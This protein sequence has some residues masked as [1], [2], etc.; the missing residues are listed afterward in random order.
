MREVGGIEEATA[1]LRDLAAKA[2]ES[3]GADSRHVLVARHQLALCAADRGDPV[4]AERELRA[5]LEATSGALGSD[6]T[7]VASVH[8]SLARLLGKHGQR[9]EAAQ[10][11]DAA[12]AIYD[13]R[14]DF[15]HPVVA[16]LREQRA[17][18]LVA[19]P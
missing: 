5:V 8:A 12:I 4:V 6:H 9:E 7:E 19:S 1:V 13:G 17:G 14:Y 11:F 3:L 2:E 18:L 10:H 15:E 16:A